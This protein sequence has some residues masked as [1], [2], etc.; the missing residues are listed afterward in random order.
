M[1]IT[2]AMDSEA[3][4]FH[5][6][7]TM[8]E[9]T[10]MITKDMHNIPRKAV[11]MLLVEMMR[12]TNEKTIAIMMPWIAEFTKAFSEAIQDHTLSVVC[13]ADFSSGMVLIR[14]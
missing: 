9:S 13:C 14:N 11:S 8:M 3:P 4:R 10:L 7:S 5:S 6:C 12:T 1:S 2:I